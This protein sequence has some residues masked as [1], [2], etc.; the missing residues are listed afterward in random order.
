M[1]VRSAIIGSVVLLTSASVAAQQIESTTPSASSLLAVTDC[2]AG[3]Q[4]GTSNCQQS[5]QSAVFVASEG[6]HLLLGSQTLT[7]HW[8]ASDS[9]GLRN[10]PRWIIEPFPLNTDKP[11]RITIRPD[12]STCVGVSPDT[13]GVTF[14]E[15]SVLQQ[16]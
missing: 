7:R 15:F 8:N 1:T 5:E 2:R 16:R 6:Y 12:L 10:T 14:Y 13:Q 3:C 4:G 11:L 9:P